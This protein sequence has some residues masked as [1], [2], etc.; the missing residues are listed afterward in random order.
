MLLELRLRNL[1]VIESVTL[2]LADGLNVLSG[3]TGAG[4]SLIVGALGLLLGERA[5]TDRVRAGAE[6]AVVEASFRLPVEGPVRGWL[7]AHGLEADD[8]LLILK[9]EVASSGRSRAWINGSPVTIAQLRALGARLVVVHGQHEAQALLDPALQRDT[10]DAFAGAL[11]AAQ[12]M[13]A[14]HARVVAVRAERDA[15]ESR[16]VDATRRADY[17][18]FVVEEIEAARLRAGEEEALDAEHRRLAHADELRGLALEAGTTL[19]G[20]PGAVLEQLARVRRTLAQ[21]QRIDPALEPLQG[22]FDGACY[23]LEELARELDQFADG[24]DIDPIRLQE[25]EARRALVTQLLRKHGPTVDAV[26]ATAAQARAELALVDDIAAARA[27][28]D[29]ELRAAL[30]ARSTVAGRLTALRQAAAD[31]LAEG[32]TRLLPDL[33]MAGGRFCVAFSSLDEPGAHGAERLD[34]R[35]ALNAGLA[36]GPLDR[37]A[38]G[39][40]LARVML[41]LSTVLA[42]SQAVPTLVFDEVDAG[43]GGTV[44]WQVGALMR[45]VARHHQVLAISHLAQIAA[46]AHHHMVVR[47]AASAGWTTADT[48]AVTGDARVVELARM[49]GGDAEREV[50][51]A[52]ARELL[53][54]GSALDAGERERDGEGAA[55][56]PRG[57]SPRRATQ[58]RG[59]PG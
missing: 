36:E 45:R 19:Q 46:C 24:I 29:A 10:L 7:D 6:R 37:V 2:P 32:V 13:A 49:L 3:E 39:G 4:K 21:L 40:E 8:D 50:S 30:E 12:E 1:A 57:S 28:V 41:A 47:K 58:R 9:R 23:A 31:V 15:L 54:R 11:E 20:G 17:L 43:V 14:A 35:V 44:A 18:R 25:V 51:R 53:E 56:A 42:R 48:E 5:A 38:S 16:R 34:F 52:H 22:T 55:P 26:L 59:K 27:R 33:G